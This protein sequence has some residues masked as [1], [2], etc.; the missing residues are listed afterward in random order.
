MNSLV[1][2]FSVFPQTDFIVRLI[3][4]DT[5]LYNYRKKL[6]LL[7]MLAFLFYFSYLA[8]RLVWVNEMMIE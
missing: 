6:F 3:S 7:N 5:Y 2:V 4:A 1:I 8:A